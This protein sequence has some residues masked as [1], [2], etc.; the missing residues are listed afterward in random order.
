MVD[1]KDLI[2]RLKQGEEK[3]LEI[4]YKIYFKPLCYFALD[5]TDDI[6]TAEEIVQN[7]IVNL[8]E[9]SKSVDANT[10]LKSYLFSSV[11]NSSINYLKHKKVEQKYIEIK[12][13]TL[14]EDS[15]SNDT[16]SDEIFDKLNENIEKLPEQCRIIFKM[17]RFDELK[18]KE[19]AEKLNLSVRTVENQIAKALKFLKSEMSDLISIILL[20]NVLFL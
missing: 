1:N 8:W 12:K 5:F 9:K 20:I 11:R 6:D 3:A 13:L 15:Y 7:T 10:N 18:A 17:N 19:I 16:Y 4:I 2:L 14:Q